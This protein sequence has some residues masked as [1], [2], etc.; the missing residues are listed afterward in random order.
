M[1]ELNHAALRHPSWS[2]IHQRLSQVE[3]AFWLLL[4]SG[5]RERARS[6]NSRGRRDSEN[7]HSSG[8]LCEL[9]GKAVNWEGKQS[10]GGYFPWHS[11]SL[12][13]SCLPLSLASKIRLSEQ[14]NSF[15]RATFCFHLHTI[16]AS[17]TTDHL[18]K[19]KSYLQRGSHNALE[20]LHKKWDETKK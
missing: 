9:R 8:L 17:W 6:C 3:R 15:P 7:T 2:V 20:L 1:N 14:A 4:P 11:L 5:L 13:S 16:T 12:S 10:F 18:H 19:E